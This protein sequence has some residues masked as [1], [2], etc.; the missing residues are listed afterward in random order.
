MGPHAASGLTPSL[1]QYAHLLKCRREGLYGEQ[2]VNRLWVVQA[3]TSFRQRADSARINADR[4][5]PAALVPSIPS[6]KSATHR[7]G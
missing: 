1:F 3:V 6:L 5:I 4:I 7:L 2:I